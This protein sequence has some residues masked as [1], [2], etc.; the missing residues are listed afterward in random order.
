MYLI[1]ISSLKKCQRL[2][3]IG[4]TAPLRESCDE[5][6]VWQ[7]TEHFTNYTEGPA[8][9]SP[10]SKLKVGTLW[11]RRDAEMLGV[12]I[13]REKPPQLP[14]TVG[15]KAI[16]DKPPPTLLNHEQHCL[17]T[18]FFRPQLKAAVRRNGGELGESIIQSGQ[19]SLT[20]GLGQTTSFQ[21]TL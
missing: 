18:Y 10:I 5:L 11:W 21:F 12:K 9:V 1:H 8:R 2:M 4:L 15:K 13:W 16:S 20:D 7:E 17:P 6:Y 14:I 19:S 3:Y